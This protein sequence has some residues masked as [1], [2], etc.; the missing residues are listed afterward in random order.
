MHAA[1]I[2]INEAIDRQIAEDTLDALKNPSAHLINI[3]P[4][5]SD[6]YQ[7]LLYDAKAIKAENARNKVRHSIIYK[8]RDLAVFFRQYGYVPSICILLAYN[9]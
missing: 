2:A 5:L 6:M 7:Q 1:V 4:E 8:T 3:Y 9:N